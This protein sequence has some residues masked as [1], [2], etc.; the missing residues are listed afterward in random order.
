M[1]MAIV[2][3]EQL[4][5]LIQTL[6]AIADGRAEVRELRFAVEGGLKV[7]VNGGMWSAP[8]GRMAVN[9]Y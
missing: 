4:E 2:E 1:Y 5:T 6:R 8:Y 9:G 7:K 3:N